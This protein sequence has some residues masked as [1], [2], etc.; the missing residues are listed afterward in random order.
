M[1][2]VAAYVTTPEGRAALRR[3][4]SEAVTHRTNLLVSDSRA[5][6]Q[7]S[8]A[9]VDAFEQELSRARATLA[10]HDLA[11]EVR[12]YDDVEQ[13]EPLLAL[14]DEVDADFIVLGIRRRS[15]VGKLVMGS[16]A[17]RVLLEADCP[18]LAVKAAE[19]AD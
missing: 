19:P 2:I 6:S 13:T 15:P 10:A 17:Q 8:G 9:D 16:K 5:A 7:Q 18:V 4:A 1:P 11:V 12:T 3:A 14:A